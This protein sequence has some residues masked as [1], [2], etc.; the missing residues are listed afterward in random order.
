MAGRSLSGRAVRRAVHGVEHPDI[1]GLRRQDARQAEQRPRRIV[2]MDA[3]PHSQPLGDGHDLRQKGDKVGAQPIGVD[4]GIAAQRL[5]QFG[6]AVAIAR[7][8]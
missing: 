6:G 3:E 5:A 2:A 7:A 8:R 4:P 1:V